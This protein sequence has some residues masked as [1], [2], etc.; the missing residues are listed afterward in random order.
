MASC[1]FFSGLPLQQGKSMAT[2]F[3][4]EGGGMPHGQT[5]NSD[6][7][8]HTRGTWRSLSGEL[9]LTKMLLKSSF[10]TTTHVNTQVRKHMKQSQIWGTVF[11][12]PPYS[13]DFTPSNLTSL[14]PS[15]L[16]SVEKVWEN[17]GGYWRSEEVAAS[18]NFKMI[19]E[20]VRYSCLS[21]AQGC[22]SWWRLCRKIRSAIHLSSYPMNMFKELNNK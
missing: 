15:K 9:D 12:Y 10:D 1:S 16:L 17:W 8:L 7:Y 2:V 6:L 5:I 22:W 13:S 18:I 14:E 21:L 19:Q 4:G 11:P 20:G 3:W